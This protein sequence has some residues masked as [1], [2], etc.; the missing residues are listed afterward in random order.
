M[1]LLFA[2]QVSPRHFKKAIVEY[3]R[4]SDHPGQVDEEPKA[5]EARVSDVEERSVGVQ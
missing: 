4:T 1:D 3:R 5:T 2:E